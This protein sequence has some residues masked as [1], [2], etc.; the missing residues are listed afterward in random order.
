MSVT[1]AQAALNAADDIDRNVIDEY[2]RSSWLLD[3]LTFDDVVNAAGNGATLTYGYTRLVKPGGAASRAVNSEYTA[4]EATKEQHTVDLKI[5]GGSF[6]I[7]RVLNAIAAGAETAF[8]MTQKI[9]AAANYFTDQL[10]NGDS[11]SNANTWDGLDTALTSTSTEVGAG[12]TGQSVDLSGVDSQAK[13]FA[14]L[15]VID[16]MLAEMDGQPTAIL[17]NRSAITKLRSAARFAV[18]LESRESFGMAV[19]TY[20]GVPLIDVGDKVTS[21]GTAS[22]II[23]TDDGITDLYAVRFALN[24]FHGV[25][26]AG[27]PLVRQWLPDFTTAGAVKTGEVEMVCAP[28]LKASR[29]AAVLRKVRIAAAA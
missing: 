10:I 20:A 19:S 4:S 15:A 23:G 25:S 7:D 22:S 2:R 14:A 17:G 11:D 26:L 28:V 8:Q 29:A 5:L 3:N 27:Q 13:A 12:A 16:S 18:A 24:G 21:D 1:L 6:Q 9:A